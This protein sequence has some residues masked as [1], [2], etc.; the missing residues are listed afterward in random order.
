VRRS[1][2]SN[3]AS[4]VNVI[5]YNPSL[6][7]DEQDRVAESAFA[8]G[9]SLILKTHLVLAA[10]AA[11]SFASATA[12]DKPVPVE[13]EPYHHVQLKNE[14]VVVIRATL[15]PGE[16]T[17][18]H[19]HSCD[20][21]GVELTNN[22]TTGQRFGEAEDSP[23]ASAP[24]D[25]F[26]DSCTGEPL[27]HRVHNVGSTTMDVVDVELLHRPEHPSTSSAGPV[28]AENPSVR[29]YRWVIAPG[30]ATAM[31]THT[32]PYLIVAAAPMQLKMTA[33][34][35][36]SRSEQVKAGDF[37]W[38]NVPVTHSLANEGSGQGLIVEFEL[39]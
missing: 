6:T 3:A 21:T 38:V 1:E 10:C 39:K 7:Q 9:R 30:T 35:G 29:V 32:R 13:Q 23:K 19:I 34:D 2:G 20:R 18:Y 8:Y 22:I 14:D 28:A 16:R 36:Q 12:Q 17:A 26:S 11:F 37:H 24:G 31:H 33:P 5:V 25:V 27:T 4:G 15:A